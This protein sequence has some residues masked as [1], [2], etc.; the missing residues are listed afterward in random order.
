VLL[1]V[2]DHELRRWLTDLPAHLAPRARL[3]GTLTYLVD[4]GEAVAADAFEV[5]LRCDVITGNER[6]V[7]ALTGTSDLDAATRLVRDAMPGANLRTWV[8]SRG[9]EGCRICTRAE[10]W[11][12]PAYAVE[13]VDPTG[14]GDAFAAGIAYGMAL[15]WD[16]V[17]TGR[18]ANALGACALGALGA[19]AGLPTMAEAAAI[20]QRP[21]IRAPGGGEERELPGASAVS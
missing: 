8:I 1:D 17:R 4:Q 9:A 19:Q 10:V 20:L 3:L 2:A 16:W 13:V 5:A 7:Q 11:D 12:I 18:L 14:A 21:E 15:H 6:E